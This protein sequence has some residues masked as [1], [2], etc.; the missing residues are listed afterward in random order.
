MTELFEDER[1]KMTQK[2]GILLIVPRVLEQLKCSSLDCQSV[3]V[4]NAWSAPSM[5]QSGLLTN[6]EKCTLTIGFEY[7]VKAESLCEPNTMGGVIVLTLLDF[8]YNSPIFQMSRF[9]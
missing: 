2:D 8:N 5:R 3:L 9:L 7:N 4:E 6:I 1:I